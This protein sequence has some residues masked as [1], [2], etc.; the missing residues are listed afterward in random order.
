[1]QFYSDEEEANPLAKSPEWDLMD[2]SLLSHKSVEW[3]SANPWTLRH[4]S[5]LVCSAP[6]GAGCSRSHEWLVW[7][8]G[9]RACHPSLLVLC[10][11]TSK[12]K[13]SKILW[14]QQDKHLHWKEMLFFFSLFQGRLCS[15]SSYKERCWEGV[16]VLYCWSQMDPWSDCQ[17][18]SLMCSLGDVQNYREGQGPKAASVPTWTELS[19]LTGHFLPHPPVLSQEI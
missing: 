13:Y 16:V 1:M 8:S 10:C 2:D 11:T 19:G 5:P 6:R 4:S 15:N 9:S 14:S 7:L 3:S 12:Q 17:E 18:M